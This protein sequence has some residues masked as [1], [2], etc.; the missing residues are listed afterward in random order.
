VFQ[1]RKF[2]CASAMLAAVST[3]KHAH[4]ATYVRRAI[5]RSGMGVSVTAAR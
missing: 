2:T 4:T 3:S 1:P 5:K